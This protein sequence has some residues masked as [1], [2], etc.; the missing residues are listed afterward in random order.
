MRTQVWSLILVSRL[1]IWHCH[2]LW[3][4]SQ[5]W[6]GPHVAV[7]VASAGSDSSDLTPSLGTSMCPRCGPKK[8]SPPKK[9]ER[10]F[11][12]VIKLMVLRVPWIIQV[13]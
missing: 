9:R 11:V 3:Y 10:G 5:T 7:A 6:L 12:S 1:Q 8:Q 13:G 4:R 2:E